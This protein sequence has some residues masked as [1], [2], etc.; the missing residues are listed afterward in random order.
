MSKEKVVLTDPNLANALIEL[1]VERLVNSFSPQDVTGTIALR[2][3]RSMRVFSPILCSAFEAASLTF[4]G[5]RDG[6]RAVEVAGHARYLR[7]LRS[8]QNA[9]YDPQEGKS[10]EVLMVVL[11]ATIIEVSV[12]HRVKAAYLC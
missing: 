6:N 4:A 1:Y 12:T 3:A 11:L 5:R 9:L 7:V 10:T 8:L 2:E